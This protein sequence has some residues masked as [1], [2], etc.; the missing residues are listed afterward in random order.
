MVTTGIF[1]F[2]EN[3]HGRAGNRTRDLTISSQRLWLLDHEAGH[4][5][6]YKNTGDVRIT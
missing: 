6:I 3:S 2:E 5:K 1:P 4:A